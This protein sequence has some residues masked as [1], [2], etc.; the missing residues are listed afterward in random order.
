MGIGSGITKDRL[1]LTQKA[2]DG[3]R[4]GAEP[5]RIADQ[6]CAGLAV[7]VAT[8]GIKTWDLAFRIRSTKCTK[9]ISL[10]RVTDVTLE[11]ARQRANQLTTAARAGRDLLEEERREKEV[12]ERRLT[13]AE[14]I[15]VYLRRRVDGRLRTARE[16]GRRLR[17]TLESRMSDFAGELR[18]R[19]IRELLDE[20]ADRGLER[21][22]EKRRQT[23][24]AMFRWAVSQDIIETDPTAGLTAYDPGT[25]GDRV[26]SAEEIAPLWSWLL[27]S[28]VS[29][30]ISF[31]LRLQLLTGARCGEVS[32][33]R[34]EEVDQENWIWTLP[35]ERSKNKRSRSTPLLGECR[36]ILQSRLAQVNRG[37]LFVTES[38]KAMQ[39]VNV[40]QYL[41]YRKSRLPIAKFTTH[42]LRRTVATGLV[43]M[44]FSLD[45]VAAVIGHEAGGRNT[46][47]LVRHYVR[48]DL[49]ARKIPVLSAWDKTIADAATG[50][51]TPRVA[52]LRSA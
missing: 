41:C 10:G 16:I 1:L 31:I 3:L 25:P 45:I 4:P 37:P 33:L 51:V 38:G 52:M 43:D 9:R 12:T 19:D 24:G 14:L 21:E 5:Y 35:A 18:R 13:I 2:I 42:D 34:A 6:R 26:L 48:T 28:L 39:S 7:R 36:S 23:V 11:A 27:S 32:G 30:D 8:N 49:V 47:T 40:G 17:R 29:P 44:G 46:Q 20:V 50:R 22:A 15:A